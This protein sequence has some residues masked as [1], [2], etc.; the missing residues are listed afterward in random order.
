M[1]LEEIKQKIEQGIQGATVEM[2]G[3]GCNC[4][5]TVTSEKFKGLSLLE[6]QKMVLATVNDEIKSG[7]L[8]ALS[9]KTKTS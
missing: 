6:Q 4:S 3:D 2:Q 7:V 8:H 5:T 9:V 1:T